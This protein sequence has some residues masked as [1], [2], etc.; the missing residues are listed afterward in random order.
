MWVPRFEIFFI[1]LWSRYEKSELELVRTVIAKCFGD[2]KPVISLNT[3]QIPAFL[4][5]TYFSKKNP[6]GAF[7]VSPISPT[8]DVKVRF[9]SSREDLKNAYLRSSLSASVLPK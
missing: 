4:Q 2:L 9:N 3:M 5:K 6:F 7:G 1:P 8:Q